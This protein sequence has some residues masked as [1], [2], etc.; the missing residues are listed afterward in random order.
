MGS[1]DKADFR[2]V[3]YNGEYRV[4]CLDKPV[5]HWYIV[6][7]RLGSGLSGFIKAV[8]YCMQNFK[9]KDNERPIHKAMD[10]RERH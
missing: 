7:S 6:I 8:R 4:E 10:N 1:P 9:I 3:R 2:I 5:G